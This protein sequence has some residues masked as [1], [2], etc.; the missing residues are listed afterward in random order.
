MQPEI[1]ELPPI[2]PSRRASIRGRLD[3]I[4]KDQS[5]KRIQAIWRGNSCRTRNRS[6]T[7]ADNPPEVLTATV[8]TR[9]RSS[10]V[11][12]PAM[13]DQLDDDDDED[14]GRDYL[15][16]EEEN[17]ENAA[18]IAEQSTIHAAQSFHNNPVEETSQSQQPQSERRAPILWPEPLIERFDNSWP[19]LSD[20]DVSEKWVYK[21]KAVLVRAVTW[22]LCA[23]KPPPVDDTRK[24]LFPR[25][26]FH[27]YVVGSEECERSIAQSAVN[28]SK[29]NWEAYLIEALGPNYQPIR[30]QTL[31]AIHIIVFAHKSIA[32]LCSDVTSGAVPTGLGNTLGNKGGVAVQ[33]SIGRTRAVFVNVHLAAHQNAVKQRNADYHKITN[34][35]PYALRRKPTHRKTGVMTRSSTQQMTVDDSGTGSLNVVSAIS[36]SIPQMHR[37]AS[38]MSTTSN[39][40]GN[41]KHL[42]GFLW[43]PGSMSRDSSGNQESNA[44]Q[45]IKPFLLD[46]SSA[47]CLANYAERLIFMGDMNYRIRGN[48]SAVSKLIDMNMQEVM[49]NNDQL[50]WSMNNKLA[51]EDLIEGPLHFK[52]TYKLDRDSDDYDTGPKRRI[53]AWTDRILYVDRGLQCLAYNADMSLRT[54]DHRPVYASFKLEIELYDDDSN[55]STPMV[56]GQDTSSTNINIV[57]SSTSAHPQALE[58]PIEA[59]QRQSVN[60]VVTSEFRSESAVCAIM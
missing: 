21:H 40:A 34:N 1:N 8:R 22:N 37:E 42:P 55:D 6:T 49:I 47:V 27:I 59:D 12:A 29:K 39:G 15:D 43:K 38:T 5:A 7:N 60:K 51:F 30:A 48:R 16:K 14:N 46:P 9:R 44:I 56:R 23:K 35:M 25:D 52:P 58:L 28:T 53:P 26:K 4:R 54:S 32:Y 17:M 33:L 57:E 10:S 19:D 2:N 50:T 45:N 13:N 18:L 24:L 20:N 41:N 11:G 3:E 36:Q 31:Q